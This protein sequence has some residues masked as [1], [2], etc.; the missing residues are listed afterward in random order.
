LN[1]RAIDVYEQKAKIAKIIKQLIPI[2]SSNKR[3]FKRIFKRLFG[4]HFS[5]KNFRKK[6]IYSTLFRKKTLHWGWFQ[7]E[8]FEFSD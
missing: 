8:V 4:T 6:H 1:Y 5:E 3:I 2:P 7:V